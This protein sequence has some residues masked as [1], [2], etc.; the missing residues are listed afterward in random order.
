MFYS[1]SSNILANEFNDGENMINAA[2]LPPITP[3]PTPESLQDIIGNTII[4]NI[5]LIA[6]IIG[7]IGISVLGIILIR[8]YRKRSKKNMIVSYKDFNIAT[9]KVKFYR[10]IANI[11]HEMSTEDIKLNQDKFKYKDKDFSLIDR[12]NIAFS[13]NDNKY[14]AFDYDSMK[15]LSFIEPTHPPKV[16]EI[17][18]LIDNWINRNV[19]RQLT[20]GLEH[21]QGTKSIII[22]IFVSL[23][24]GLVAGILVGYF[25]HSQPQQATQTAKAFVKAVGVI[26][27]A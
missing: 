15:Q 3:S 25:G 21:P 11:F 13:D 14:Y 26:L 23:I 12:N 2:I 6:V 16:K 17:M 24:I 20:E 22:A 4:S 7:A 5:L 19:I 27:N 18:E 10:K 9:L 8:D 1:V